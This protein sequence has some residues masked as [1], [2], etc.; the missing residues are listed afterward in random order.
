[1]TDGD[2]LADKLLQVL[3]QR[4]SASCDENS[5]QLAGSQAW[6][7]PDDGPWRAHRAARG[8]PRPCPVG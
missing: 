8:R 1:M 4:L 3:A 5:T 2:E 6:R 7:G